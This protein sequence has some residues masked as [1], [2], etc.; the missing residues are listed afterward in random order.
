MVGG[1]KNLVWWEVCG[2]GKFFLVWVMIIFLTSWR[3]DLFSHPP[4]RDNPGYKIHQSKVITK[5]IFRLSRWFH[6]T[7]TSLYKLK[8]M[9]VIH[10]T[11][12]E[13]KSRKKKIVKNVGL[14]KTFWWM[15]ADSNGASVKHEIVIRC[16]IKQHVIPKWYLGNRCNLV[17]ITET[18]SR[19]CFYES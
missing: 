8:I 4:N 18:Y 10:Q 13:E 5:Q 2:K 7:L 17:W 19:K 6:S 9:K 11:K 15:L 16:L 3:G 1:K 12:I 14:P